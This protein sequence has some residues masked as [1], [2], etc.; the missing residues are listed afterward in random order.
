VSAEF[1]DDP[2]AA[3]SIGQVHNGSCTT[4]DGLLSSFS[5][6]LRQQRSEMNW[7]T[8]NCAGVDAI[9]ACVVEQ[10][11]TGAPIDFMAD[12]ARPLPI[13]VI[14]EWLGLQAETLRLLREQSPA[15]IRMHRRGSR[16]DRESA[17]SGD[18]PA[19]YTRAGRNPD[20]RRHRRR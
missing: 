3:A 2:I 20:R 8:P 7:P 4:G 6:P 18:D 14:G 19:A 13:A 11:P 9:A 1:T 12:I 17:G 15:I 5:I 16:T 10:I